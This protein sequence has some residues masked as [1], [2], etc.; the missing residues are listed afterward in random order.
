MWTL[1]LNPRFSD[2]DALGHINN[3]SLPRWFEEAREPLFRL[4]SPDLDIQNWQLILAR[5]EVDFIGELF[6]G[7]EVEIRTVMSKIGNSSMTLHH[8][9]WQDGKL[10]AKGTAVMVHFDLK[11]KQSKTIPEPIRQQLQQHLV[12]A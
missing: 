11:A 4:F 6:Y 2:T 1:H 9:A 10:A 3:A 5:I 12:T 8:E 7:R